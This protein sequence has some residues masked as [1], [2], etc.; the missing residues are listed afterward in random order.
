[1][2][3]NPDADWQVGDWFI[4]RYKSGGINHQMCSGERCVVK[5]TDEEGAYFFCPTAQYKDA[6]RFAFWREMEQVQE[7][8]M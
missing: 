2:K 7:V 4:Y 1:M 6:R 8:L 5:E 3:K